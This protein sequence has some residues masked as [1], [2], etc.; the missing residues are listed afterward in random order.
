MHEYQGITR[1]IRDSRCSDQ[2]PR[3]QRKYRQRARCSALREDQREIS[4][5]H[6]AEW[7]ALINKYIETI[8]VNG[9][10]PCEAEQSMSGML[11][12]W[13]AVSSA[14]MAKVG[15]A[16]R[17]SQLAAPGAALPRPPVSSCGASLTPLARSCRGDAT[18]HPVRC[19]LWERGRATDTCP[20]ARPVREHRS[21][22]YDRRHRPRE[23]NR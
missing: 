19:V 15:A 13:I 2:R 12:L 17:P 7:K 3:R 14:M 8:P 1:S 21:N 18:R 16:A 6:D 10:A 4:F 11:R 20:R 23:R 22:R 9:D 5:S